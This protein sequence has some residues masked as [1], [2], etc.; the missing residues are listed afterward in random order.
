MVLVLLTHSFPGKIDRM[1]VFHRVITIPDILDNCYAAV[2]FLS[3]SVDTDGDFPVSIQ[4]GNYLKLFSWKRAF[5][6]PSGKFP[7]L[8]VIIKFQLDDT[9]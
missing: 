1:Y 9:E 3:Q 2:C 4:D 6:R 5:Y 7:T 8:Q